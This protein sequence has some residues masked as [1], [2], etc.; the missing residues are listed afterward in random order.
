MNPEE[1]IF[2]TEQFRL[3]MK[4]KQIRQESLGYEQFVNQTI[5]HIEN[6][7]KR[8][9]SAGQGYIAPHFPLFNKNVEGLEP[10]LYVFAGESN[11]GK[12]GIMASLFWDYVLNPD[13]HLYGIYFS[14]DDAKCELYP[15]IIAMQQLIPIG[16][17]KK[18]SV[19]LEKSKLPEFEYY[20]EYLVKRQLGF[21]ALKEQAAS[22]SILDATDD[23]C[24]NEKEM[25]DFIKK[26]KA[27]MKERDENANIIIAIDALDD[28]RLKD[29]TEDET[30]AIAKA[31][32]KWATTLDIPIFCTK[33]LKKLNANRRPIMDDLRNSNTLHYESSIVFLV[34]NDVSKNKGQAKIYYLETEDDTKLP[35]IELD[36]GKNKKSSYKGVTFH[37]FV[38][39]YSS[40]IECSDVVNKNYERSLYTL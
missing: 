32:K 1:L 10:G 39:D 15:R 4:E 24:A 29:N 40:V 6:V 7:N 5:D 13:N 3:F 11:S 34:H 16:C 18:P 25:Y 35:V 9:W 22:V 28:I 19:Y 8:N 20:K 38:P 31:V 14:L 27:I 17:V 12:T 37:H 30:E 33:H 23:Y 2:N 36:W 21:E 26:F